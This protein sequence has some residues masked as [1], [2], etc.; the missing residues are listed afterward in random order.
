MQS[1]VAKSDYETKS[2]GGIGW[3]KPSD[4]G[5]KSGDSAHGI[6]KPRNGIG[7]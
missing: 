6:I 1:D 5:H 2:D 4:F 3:P 7:V